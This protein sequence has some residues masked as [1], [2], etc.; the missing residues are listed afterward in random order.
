LVTLEPQVLNQLIGNRFVA[1]SREVTQCVIGTMIIV[2]H[3]LNFPFSAKD[4]DGC[5]IPSHRRDQRH[6]DRGGAFNNIKFKAGGDRKWSRERG[7]CLQPSPARG[8]LSLCLVDRL[9]S[10]FNA[11]CSGRFSPDGEDYS[12]RDEIKTYC[13][14]SQ[15][16]FK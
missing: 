12:E 6:S 9:V 15:V 4:Y 14:V 13:Y 5:C 8:D 1:A 16:L 10:E 3:L 2:L 7:C 11:T